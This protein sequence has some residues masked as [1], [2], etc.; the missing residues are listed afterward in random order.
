MNIDWDGLI[1]EASDSPRAVL[2]E[3]LAKADEIKNVV[4]VFHDHEGVASTFYAAE[5]MYHVIAML[6]YAK[7]HQMKKINRAVDD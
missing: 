6:D 4:I 1:N 5:S 2:A 7:W 3:V